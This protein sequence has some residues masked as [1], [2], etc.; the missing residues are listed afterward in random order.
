MDLVI[1]NKFAGD[2]TGIL[3]DNGF[4]LEES[5][6]NKIYLQDS[7]RCIPRGLGNFVDLVPSPH[8]YLGSSIY[9]SLY[10]IG[11][12]ELAEIVEDRYSRLG[13][14]N[15]FTYIELDNLDNTYTEEVVTS[16]YESLNITD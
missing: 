1:S 8:I 14:E 15:Q 7:V 6:V 12:G 4:Y 2:P 16:I 10:S 3:G 9:N 11:T 5:S 13:L